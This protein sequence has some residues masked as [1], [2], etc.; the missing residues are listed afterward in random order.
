MR[1]RIVMLVV[2]LLLA[3]AFAAHAVTLSTPVIQGRDVIACV[4][5]NVGTRDA[6]LAAFEMFDTEGTPFDA[7]RGPC[8]GTLGPRRSCNIFQR[9]TSLYGFC[10][11]NGNGKLRLS[12][13]GFVGDAV[14]V[15]LAGTA[16]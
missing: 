5:T 16:D 14:A 6:T 4:V 10:Q 2:P 13:L 11:A 15:T 12:V 1:A 8:G 7:E 3:S 9:G